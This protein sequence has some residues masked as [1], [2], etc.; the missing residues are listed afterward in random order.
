MQR[1]H[2]WRNVPCYLPEKAKDNP[3]YQRWET[4]T[5]EIREELG[6][7]TTDID[8]T[9]G[10]KTTFVKI[11]DLFSR[12]RQVFERLKLE[13][14]ELKEIDFANMPYHVV[15]ES[16]R[17]INK[18][19]QQVQGDI[20]EIE[21]NNT[22]ENIKEEIESVKQELA[23]KQAKLNQEK[24]QKSDLEKTISNLNKR[25]EEKQK[26]LKTLEEKDRNTSMSNILAIPKI[27]QYPQLPCVGQLFQVNSQSYL[28]I[29]YWEDYEEGKREAERLKAKLCAMN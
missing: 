17:R 24:N 13:L 9:L 8:D 27:E 15:E 23:D 25:I 4:K 20:D 28:A 1:F 22:I 10:K 26:Q 19:N 7:I 14:N 18:L 2:T 29:E 11:V 21:R 3:L 6:K 5:K 12:K 16:I